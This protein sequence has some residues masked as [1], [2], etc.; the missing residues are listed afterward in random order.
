[1]KQ[2]IIVCLLSFLHIA[3]FAQGARSLKI[4]E[5]V[6]N[7]ANG[8][9]DEYGERSGWIEIANTSYS[10]VSV[11]S[12]YLTTDRAAL[13][14]RLSVPERIR[15]MSQIAKDESRTTLKAKQRILLFADGHCN[16]GTLHANFTFDNTKPVFIALFDANGQTLLDSITVP[17]LGKDQSYARLLSKDGE[18]V[19]WRIADADKVTPNGPNELDGQA[20]DKVA[21]WKK[22]DPHGIAMAIIAMGIVFLC[23][24][25][26]YVFFHAAGYLLSRTQKIA[27][28]KPISTI[29]DKAHS[30]A[31]RAKHGNELQGVDKE[32]YI[33]VIA[34][35]L[36]EYEE[37]VHDVESNIL[38]IKPRTNNAWNSKESLMR[39]LPR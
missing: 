33:A 17:V 1:M 19:V 39:K 18:S 9:Q 31:N 23:L 21:Q 7:N 32:I 13:N 2:T 27:Q 36:K 30:A 24:I 14:P 35:A 37:D 3:S 11:A 38:T 16:R 22:N 12:M 4:N 5:V 25:L 15:M 29:G 20:D 8:Y 34:M 10:T 6:T 28:I 26:L